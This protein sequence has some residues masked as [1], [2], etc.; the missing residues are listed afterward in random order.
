MK[1][2][3]AH[4]PDSTRV[5]IVSD[6]KR[7]HEN[8]SRVLARILG[9]SEPLLMLLRNP[10]GGL[11]EHVLRARFALFGRRAMSRLEAAAAVPRL[12]RPDAA[13]AFREL[14][15]EIKGSARVFTVS[16]GTPPATLNLLLARLLDVPAVCV[17]TP[18]LLPRRRFDLCVVPQHDLTE[19][20][21]GTDALVRRS[22]VNPLTDEGVRPT[23][24]HHTLRRHTMIATPMALS[25]H[26]SAAA[27]LQASQLAREGGF[28]PTGRYWALALGGPSRG[29]GWSD[30][31]MAAQLDAF[32]AQARRAGA[33]LLVTNSRRTPDSFTAHIRAATADR[34]S[35]FLDGR[36]DPRNPLPAFYELAEAVAVSADSFS[37]VCEAVQAGFRPYLLQPDPIGPRLLRGLQ[38]LEQRGLVELDSRTN[39][40][41]RAVQVGRGEPNRFYAELR[42]DVRAALGI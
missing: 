1:N 16:T 11:A 20:D 19:N 26:D 29:A 10:E 39:E 40:G 37:M 28:D 30:E 22:S 3:S 14:A 18:S 36:D 17:M 42:Q 12:L 41:L 23:M 34:A 6:A 27:Q 15:G 8:Q 21:S 4:T 33:R 13:A 9:D 2:E 35:Y 32:L 24:Q 5:I 7:G 31:L 25:Y 38:A